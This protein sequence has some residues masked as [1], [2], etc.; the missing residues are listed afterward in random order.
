MVDELVYF[1][2]VKYGPLTTAQSWLD[3]NHTLLNIQLNFH[4]PY[5]GH[6]SNQYL[7]APTTNDGCVIWSFYHTDTNNIAN[8]TGIVSFTAYMMGRFTVVYGCTW[9]NESIKL[10][11]NNVLID[12]TTN[13]KKS[14][15]FDAEKDDVIEIREVY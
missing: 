8:N 9:T 15:T 2:N 4:T 7:S 11:K 5:F 12:E 6:T 1:S 3:T 14:F 10:Y 13:V